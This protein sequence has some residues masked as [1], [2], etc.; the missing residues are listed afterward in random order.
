MAEAIP[1]Q[2]SP[3]LSL[4][5]F[6]HAFFGRRGG[7]STGEFSSLNFSALTG[8]DEAHV[9]RNLELAG[10]ALGIE[11]IELY[12]LRQVHGT[13][14]KVI[15]GREDQKVVSQDEGDIVLTNVPG[16]AAAIRT[17]D[18]VPILLASPDTGWVSAC[19]SGW[20]GCVK[21]AAGAAVLAMK[22]QGCGRII[23][24]IGPHISAD[25]FEV[26]PDVSEALL[27]ASPDK[28]IVDESREKPHVNLRRMVRAQLIEAGLDDAD[29]DDVPGCTVLDSSNYFSFRRDKERSGRMMSAIVAL[30]R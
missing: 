24:A 13:D 15:V 23:A 20:Q 5:G 30:A 2:T 9:Q 6:T 26:S 16:T 1:F 27:A 25:A 11:P 28:C 18:C 4:A 14:V 29:I 21:N 8:D 22:S 19:H 10:A 3:L 12:F 7:V 17:A